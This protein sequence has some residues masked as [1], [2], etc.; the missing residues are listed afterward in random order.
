M[1]A[2]VVALV[3]ESVEADLE[4]E[5]R[6][7]ISMSHLAPKRC[8]MLGNSTLIWLLVAVQALCGAYFLWEIGAG[9]FGFD[10]IQLRW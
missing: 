1:A 8:L 5:G 4:T 9:I 10:T 2:L 6:M 7:E 3:V